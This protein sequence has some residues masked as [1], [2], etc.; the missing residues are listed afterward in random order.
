MPDPLWKK[1]IIAAEGFFDGR[2]AFLSLT[3]TQKLAW[4]SEAA[5]SV[6]VLARC[7]PEAGCNALFEADPP[8][9]DPLA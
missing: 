6:Y 8:G 9:T 7:N 4:L 3:F 5:V 1:R 2:T